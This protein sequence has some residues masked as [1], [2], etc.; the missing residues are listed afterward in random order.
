MPG[1]F[2]FENFN[3]TEYKHLYRT[4]YARLTKVNA[5]SSCIKLKIPGAIVIHLT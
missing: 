5:F 2:H 4:K 3:V 1:Y